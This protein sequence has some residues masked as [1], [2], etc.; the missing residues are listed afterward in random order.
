MKLLIMCE[1]PNELAVVNILLDNDCF[2]FSR[3]DLINL[4]AFHARQIEKSTAVQT[5]LNIYT[6]DF[7]IIRIGDKMS[8]SLKIPKRYLERVVSS[9]KY[10]TKPELEILLIIAEG[11]LTEYEKFKSKI[12]PKDFSKQNIF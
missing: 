4:T 11:K 8:D 1:G 10:C 6:D 12:S 9:E 7:K 3:D 2:I 5:A